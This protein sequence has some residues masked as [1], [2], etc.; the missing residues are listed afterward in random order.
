MLTK[1]EIDLLDSITNSVEGVTSLLKMIEKFYT[2]KS[3]VKTLTNQLRNSLAAISTD[4]AKLE[5]LL[6]MKDISEED[7]KIIARNHNACLF[8]KLLK[9]DKE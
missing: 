9:E 8:Q 2:S 6:N 4:T 1:R 7:K 3:H 5:E